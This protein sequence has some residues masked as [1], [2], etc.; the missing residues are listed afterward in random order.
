MSSTS[1]A[2]AVIFDLSFAIVVHIFFAVGSA[3]EPYRARNGAHPVSTGDLYGG[4]LT[5]ELTRDVLTSEVPPGGYPST[6][7]WKLQVARVVGEVGTQTHCASPVSVGDWP[8]P[9]RTEFGFEPKPDWQSRKWRM[10]WTT[11]DRG[12]LV[13]QGGPDTP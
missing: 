4:D 6:C 3:H 1:V 9:D 10:G 13:G 7:D 12:N 8:S 5:R 11:W 2:I